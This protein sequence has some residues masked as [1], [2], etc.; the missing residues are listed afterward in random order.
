M[1]YMFTT[2][3][4]KYRGNVFDITYRNVYFTPSSSQNGEG[5]EL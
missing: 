1:S 4:K 2:Q 5:L 3:L